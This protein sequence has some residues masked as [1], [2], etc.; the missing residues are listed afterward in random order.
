[1]DESGKFVDKLEVLEAVDAINRDM[2]SLEEGLMPGTL[3]LD[4]SAFMLSIL[5]GDSGFDELIGASH[6]TAQ[7]VTG[8]L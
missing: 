4:W 6:D 5:K 1:M 3:A 8:S 2:S 7:V